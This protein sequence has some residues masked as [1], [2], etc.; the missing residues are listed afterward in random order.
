MKS[1]ASIGNVEV[2]RT[3]RFVFVAF[4][5]VGVAVVAITLFAVAQTRGLEDRPREIVDNMLTSVRL[6][7]RLDNEVERKR[8]LID[9]HILTTAPEEMARLE[10]Q[11]AAID[12]R[13]AGLMKAYEPW[14]SQPGEHVSWDKTRADIMA[15]NEPIA[16]TLALSRQNH[17][18]A[19]REAIGLAATRFDQVNDDV[20]E[21]V[22]INETSA[23]SSLARFSATRFR[24]TL[25]LLGVGLLGLAVTVL[26]GRWVAVQVTRREQEIALRA[27]M[28]EERNREL[29]AFAGQVAHDIRGPLTTIGL[30]TTQLS[31]VSQELRA[32]EILRRGVQ[33]MQALV[34]DL[35][36][37]AQVEARAGGSCDPAAVAAQISG[38]FAP[39]LAGENGE[40]R[41]K[42]APSQVS[43][44][45][46]LLRQALTNLTE[47]A[48]KYR[49]PDVAPEV[50]ISGAVTGD[51]YELR[52]SDNGLGMSSD[53]SRRVFEPFYRSPR[54]QD[55]PGT[56][57]GLS[58]VSR[59][60]KASGGT[61][62]VETRLDRG[63]TFI[64]RLPLVDGASPRAGEQ[65]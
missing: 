22:S 17:N 56:G 60:V 34:D 5:F 11:L 61:L 38:D 45:E 51:L 28:L 64:M 13:I 44:S 35:L 29:G 52:V 9:E 23:A 30:A 36:A 54:T 63:S 48:V 12:A 21:I 41:L 43:C 26:L 31:Q 33:K 25:T 27:R 53:D 59:V 8:T 47:N 3:R 1:D 37:L 58:I 24:L 42:L 46:G 62:A 7:G 55:R 15:L 6:V 39:R 4:A 18:V 16:R 20:D 50:E 65:G 32:T 2:T 14:A 10:A 57:L 40:L 19:A 49:R